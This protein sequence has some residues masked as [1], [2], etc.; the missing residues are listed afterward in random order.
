MSLLWFYGSISTSL[1]VM[2]IVVVSTLIFRWRFVL[3][4]SWY[5]P[6]S[7]DEIEYEFD[8]FI[9]Y[10]KHDK[11]WVLNQLCQN[12]EINNPPGV[13]DLPASRDMASYKLCSHQRDFI[14]G[15]HIIDNITEAHYSDRHVQRFPVRQ[16]VAT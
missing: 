5:K 7:D 1:V 12:L 10:N 11:D 6:R 2:V 16:L 15:M 8:S 13:E 3:E 9:V 4:V 14:V